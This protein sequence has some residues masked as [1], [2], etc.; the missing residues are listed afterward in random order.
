M[1]ALITYSIGASF[2]NAVTTTIISKLP[3]KQRT[4]VGNATDRSIWRMEAVAGSR[5]ILLHLLPFGTWPREDF[6]CPWLSLGYSLVRGP[7]GFGKARFTHRTLD[8]SRSWHKAMI[9]FDNEGNGQISTVNL[10]YRLVNVDTN[11]SRAYRS[12]TGCRKPLPKP[13]RPISGLGSGF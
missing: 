11:S 3:L 13:H 9:P 8:R 12:G 4:S 2:Y 1:L 6:R 5:T 10:I 7:L